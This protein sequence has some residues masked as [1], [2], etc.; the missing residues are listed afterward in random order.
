MEVACLPIFP[1]DG[2]SFSRVDLGHLHLIISVLVPAP[3]HTVTE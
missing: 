2:I 3:L 1:V